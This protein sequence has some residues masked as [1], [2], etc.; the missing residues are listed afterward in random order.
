MNN[1]IHYFIIVQKHYSWG[2]KT[3]TYIVIFYTQNNI[4]ECKGFDKN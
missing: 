2:Q 4:F 1:G 3:F